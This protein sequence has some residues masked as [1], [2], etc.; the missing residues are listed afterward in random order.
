MQNIPTLPRSTL[1][2]TSYVVNGVVTP[3]VSPQVIYTG[4]LFGEL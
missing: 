1:Y 4:H 2:I 3:L